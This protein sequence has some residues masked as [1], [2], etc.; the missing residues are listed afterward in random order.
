[1]ETRGIRNNNPANIKRG[2]QWKGLSPVQSD[3]VFCQFVSMEYGVRALVCLL[4]TYF[5][6]YKLKSIKS[7]IS[8]FCPDNTAKSYIDFLVV[9]MRRHMKNMAEM[10]GVT[11]SQKSI[12]Y[13]ASDSF[14]ENTDM[15]LFF[16]R[17]TP[18]V[19][20]FF[21]IV[22]ICWVESRYSLDNVVYERVLKLL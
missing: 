2:S 10:D 9:F 5:Y 12:L 16:T 22:G 19:Y 3:K 17:R 4:R 15:C 7:I 8:R 18:S 6:K 1:M 14:D 21:L 11:P 13:T 20:C